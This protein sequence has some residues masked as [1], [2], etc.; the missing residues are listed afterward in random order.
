MAPPSS[1]TST[2]RRLRPAGAAE[3][4]TAPPASTVPKQSAAVEAAAA[5]A[6]QRHRNAMWLRRQ[7]H[8]GL[9][10]PLTFDLTQRTPRKQEDERQRMSPVRSSQSG[11][12]ASVSACQPSVGL[13]SKA[14]RR[15][16][17]S[18]SCC[19]FL[20]VTSISCPVLGAVS[21]RR[22]RPERRPGSSQ[23]AEQM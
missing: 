9:G 2:L 6:P 22:R 21:P 16:A 4:P 15:S 3:R 11:P 8:A 1:Q 18:R 5:A 13:A 12:E 7:H 23:T 14:S 10:P 20:N 19:G 17:A